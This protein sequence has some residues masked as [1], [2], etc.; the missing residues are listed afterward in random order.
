MQSPLGVTDIGNICGAMRVAILQKDANGVYVPTF[1]WAPATDIHLRE[2]EDK[3]YEILTPEHED[4]QYEE[5]YLYF[6][7]SSEGN[8]PIVAGT[9]NGLYV[10]ESTGITY[11][12]GELT[13]KVAIGELIGGQ[14]N[15]FRLVIWVDGNDRECHNAMLGGRVMVSLHFGL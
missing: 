3:T 15:D 10:D 7:E 9:R 11:A 2:T 12:W 1:I 8:D 5:S 4:F 6:G 14:S 13:T